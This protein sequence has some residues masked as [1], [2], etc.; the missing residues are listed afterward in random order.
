MKQ[1]QNTPNDY[2]ILVVD[3]D[4]ACTK[5]VSSALEFENYQVLVSHSGSEALKQ[6][7]SWHPDLVLLDVSMPGLN[8]LE[9]L[10]ALRQSKSYVS[11][12]FVSGK[13]GTDDVVNGL[14]CGADDYIRKPFDIKELLAR[15]RTQLRIK[16]LNDN[17]LKANNRLKELIDID[18]LTGLYNMRSLYDRLDHE[19]L[20]AKRFKRGIC[21]IML[22][23]DYFKSVND[24]N[25]HLFGSFVLSEVG[26]IIK[27]N[28]RSVDFAARYGGDEFLI[29]LTEIDLNGAKIFAERL[30]QIISSYEFSNDGHKTHQTVSIG[31]AVTDNGCVDVTA[32]KLV[33]SA[34]NCLYEAK[35]KGRNCVVAKQHSKQQ[36]S[37]FETQYERAE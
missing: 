34:D 20:R 9:T 29:V 11:V 16:E 1:K 14:D 2:K 3:D 24:T 30:R 8:G 33:R 25:D 31:L 5:I 28:I 35:E 15:V 13:S 6:I 10:K 7:K 26:K 27:S 19:I 12:L 21:V 23:M 36:S 32:R 4:P 17:L 18:D 37:H 22:D